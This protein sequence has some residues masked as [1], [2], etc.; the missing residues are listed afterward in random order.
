MIVNGNSTQRS[1]ENGTVTNHTYDDARQLLSV[2]HRTA[3]GSLVR[4]GYAYDKLGNRTSQKWEDGRVDQYGYD[5]LSQLIQA[6]YAPMGATPTR[7]ATLARTTKYAYD[8]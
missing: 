5:P 1:L 4:L 3:A 7:K 6:Q 8:P 2:D